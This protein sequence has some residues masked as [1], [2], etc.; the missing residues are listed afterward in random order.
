M[1]TPLAEVFGHYGGV[2]AKKCLSNHVYVYCG[3]RISLRGSIRQPR[4]LTCHHVQR[5]NLLAKDLNPSI[6]EF[7]H[8]S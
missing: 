7:A 4:T 2:I 6:V 5:R 1:H 8:D 3:W